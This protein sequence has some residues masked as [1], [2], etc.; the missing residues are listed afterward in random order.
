MH[1]LIRVGVWV[2]RIRNKRTK[3]TRARQR[4]AIPPIDLGIRVQRSDQSRGNGFGIPFG[5]SY[6]A[7]K[8]NTRPRK[9]KGLVK[10]AWRVNKRIAMH[11][12]ISEEFGILE[13]R[14]HTKHATLFGPRKISLESD[15]VIRGMVR[16][17]SAQLNCGPRTSAR[18]W[19]SK[20]HGFHGPKPKRINPRPRD[21]LG[22]LAGAK[23][24]CLFE[25]LRHYPLR[26]NKLMPE[27]LVLVTLKRTV[28]VV[29]QPLLLIS[30]L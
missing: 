27:N 26:A 6:L 11:D 4:K 30:R 2:S 23:Q 8:P 18:T 24:I 21:L 16:V 17:F 15:D 3:C 20:A 14:N 28:K 13:T 19:I 22:G 10:G 9:G 12:S 29:A 7:R 5:T 1:R 25:L